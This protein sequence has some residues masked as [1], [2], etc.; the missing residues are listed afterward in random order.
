MTRSG[1]SLW[2]WTLSARASPATSTDSPIV[3]RWSRI[4]STSRGRELVGLE[5]EHRLVAE[6]L[7]GVGHEGRRLG[8]VAVRSRAATAGAW[9]TR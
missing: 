5:Q 1:R 3:S 7:V 4:A 2:T 9:P 6:A 8:A